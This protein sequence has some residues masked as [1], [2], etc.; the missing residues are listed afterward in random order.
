MNTVKSSD[1][2]SHLSSWF[3]S[4]NSCFCDLQSAF[5]ERANG[6]LLSKSPRCYLKS[7]KWSTLF[8]SWW[9]YC[10]VR[11]LIAPSNCQ[12]SAP[13]F[14][15]DRDN[16]CTSSASSS[17]LSSFTLPQP[18]LVHLLLHL[19]LLVSLSHGNYTCL[20]ALFASPTS[21]HG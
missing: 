16:M 21:S 9:R 19:L 17:R 13:P 10:R 5:P 6:H 4:R 20:F 18:S 7:S 14:P 11:T 3:R 8:H 2:F 12:A 1:A 15:C